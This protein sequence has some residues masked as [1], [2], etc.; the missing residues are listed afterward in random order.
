MKNNITEIYMEDY[1]K[2][3]RPGVPLEV[4]IFVQRIGEIIQFINDYNLR[5]GWTGR[6]TDIT[7]ID[8]Y[9]QLKPDYK[10]TRDEMHKALD[11][12]NG[13]DI[14]AIYEIQMEKSNQT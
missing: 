9:F 5:N 12:A 11:R 7:V 3:A 10:I 13:D 2:Y 8:R 14:R 6:T 1:S 4:C